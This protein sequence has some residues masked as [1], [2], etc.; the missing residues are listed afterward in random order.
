MG[1]QNLSI[2]WEPCQIQLW[3]NIPTGKHTSC[4]KKHVQSI[5]FNTQCHHHKNVAWIETNGQSNYGNALVTYPGLSLGSL[6]YAKQ[7]LDNGREC[8]SQGFVV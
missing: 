7:N 6:L 2:S 4:P 5:F 1:C 8:G 3:G